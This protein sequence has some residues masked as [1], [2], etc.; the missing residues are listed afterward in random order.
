M[1]KKYE[2]WRTFNPMLYKNG[3]GECLEKEILPEL[4]K[5]IK[6]YESR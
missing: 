3:I 1:K 5:D 6:N 2:N 4:Q